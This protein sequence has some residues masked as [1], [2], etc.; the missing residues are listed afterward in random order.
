MDLKCRKTICKHNNKYA[1]M[2]KEILVDRCTNCDT[3]E[4]DP[5]KQGEHLQDVSKTMFEAAPDL[6]PYRHNN[7]CKINCNA[8]CLFNKNGLCQANGITM[9]AGSKDGIC[10][11]FIEK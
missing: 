8:K 4:K 3:Y 5:K 1:C 2:A 9:L 7:E 6:H 11:T 10:G